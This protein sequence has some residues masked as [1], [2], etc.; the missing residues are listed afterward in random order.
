[1]DS[2][3]IKNGYTA[4]T[5]FSNYMPF[6]ITGVF[7]LLTA[8]VTAMVTVKLSIKKFRAERR[9]EKKYEAY[10]AAIKNLSQSQGNFNN[11]FL[12]FKGDLQLDPQKQHNLVETH[13][14]A[15]SDLRQAI[16][17]GGFLLSNSSTDCLQGLMDKAN[18][19]ME[20]DGVLNT[21]IERNK[22]NEIDSKQW[23]S[24]IAIAFEDCLKEF[25]VIGKRD[26]KLDRR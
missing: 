8:I 14:K 16:Y 13:S 5:E 2:M 4:A 23:A 17:C 24:E 26:L 19:T 9:W 15:M 12:W 3:A 18:S 1:M 21:V 25:I 10:E 6:I 22:S 20:I 7:S 11:L